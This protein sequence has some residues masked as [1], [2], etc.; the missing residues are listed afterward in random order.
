MAPNKC[1]NGNRQEGGKGEVIEEI[2]RCSGR[3]SIGW[4]VDGREE[5]RLGI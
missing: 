5:C 1:S 3:E 2:L 4:I